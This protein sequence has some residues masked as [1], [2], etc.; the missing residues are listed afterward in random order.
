MKKLT[1]KVERFQNLIAILEDKRKVFRLA[2]IVFAL[3]VALF[4]GITMLAL[5]LKKSFTYSD[6]TTNAFGTTTIMDEQKQVS[7]FLFNTAE[8]WANSGIEVKKGDVI[9]VY[10]SGSAHTAIHHLQNATQGNYKPNEDY[11]DAAGARMAAE[12]TR[13]RARRKFRLA[14]NLP[15]SALVMQVYGGVDKPIRRPAEY[16][17]NFYFIAHHR[18]NILIHEDG[19]LYFA[20]NDI[21]L[22]R[23]T[24]VQMKENN[25]ESM[26]QVAN[27]TTFKGVKP[28]DLKEEEKF[29]KDAKEFLDKFHDQL[30]STPLEKG[31]R[32]TPDE[33]SLY[34]KLLK[35]SVF[36]FGPYFNHELNRQD[37]NTLKTELDYYYEHDYDQAW[38]DDNVGSFL[39]VVEK[40]YRE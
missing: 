22:D 34:R 13:D 15:Q 14:A 1:I 38:Y 37:L 31:Y 12:E 40:N 30:L 36:Q 18:E 29:R 2:G 39:I 10:S 16:D 28:R 23:P 9:S 33:A 26:T 24:I 17:K 35:R 3:G 7:Y 8:L 4:F 11:F 6:I 25:F 21:V 32:L 19:T 27:D 20:V 5:Q